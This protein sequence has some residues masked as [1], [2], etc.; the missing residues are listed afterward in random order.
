MKINEFHFDFSIVR[1]DK[2]KKKWVPSTA[3]VKKGKKEKKSDRK[4]DKSERSS[5]K[6]KRKAKEHEEEDEFTPEKNAIKESAKN[7][8]MSRLDV[9]IHL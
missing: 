7:A 8:V 9:S 6:E 4:H 3:S 1:N 5:K 2:R